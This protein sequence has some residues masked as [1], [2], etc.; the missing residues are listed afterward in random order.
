MHN[1]IT[2]MKYTITLILCGFLVMGSFGDEDCT[3]KA[4][5]VNDYYV[6]L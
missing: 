5:E 6:Y 4:Q 1:S 2:N 3:Q